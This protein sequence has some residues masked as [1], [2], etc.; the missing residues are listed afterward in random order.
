MALDDEIKAMIE[1]FE[2]PIRDNAVVHVLIDVA[3]FQ[4]IIPSTS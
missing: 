4:K 2:I 1:Q 3:I